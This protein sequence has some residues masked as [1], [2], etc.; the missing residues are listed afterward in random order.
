MRALDLFCGVGGV[1]AGLVRAGFD[2]VGVDNVAQPGYP[3]EFVLGDAMA[4]LRDVDLDEFDVVCASPPC[5]RYSSA[6]QVSGKRDDHPD[7]VEPVLDELRRWGG[8]YAVENVPGSPMP[9]PLILC[10]SEFGLGAMCAD[11]VWRQLRRHRLFGSN[12][13]MMRPGGCAHKGQP[14][15]VYGGGGGQVTR[16]YMANSAEA[17][18]ALG[19]DWAA[20]RRQ[21]R[22]A[23][24][25]VYA[26][27]IGAYLAAAL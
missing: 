5:P 23:I 24:P 17:A 25:P 8:P 16:G 9:N 1:S 18:E 26:E 11:G 2:V 12:V 4:F 13:T 15:G 27:W 22:N 6:T 7:L 3:C 20:N 14:V 21:L 19:I 10:G